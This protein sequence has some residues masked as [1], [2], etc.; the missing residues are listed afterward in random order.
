MSTDTTPAA[1][2]AAKKK[3]PEKSPE[4]TTD[5]DLIAAKVK[6][7]L[8]PD[9]AAKAVARQKAADKQAKA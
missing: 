7:G 3:A 4:K 5:E 2:K 6:A 9:Q 8:T 1:K